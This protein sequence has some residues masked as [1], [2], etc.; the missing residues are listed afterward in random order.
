VELV[1]VPLDELL[2]RPAV[3]FLR[4]LYERSVRIIHT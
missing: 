3:A 4:P 2:E 1:L